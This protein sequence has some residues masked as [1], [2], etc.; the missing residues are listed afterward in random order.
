MNNSPRSVRGMHDWLAEK[1]AD[2]ERLE[3]CARA[4]FSCFGYG[5][6]RTPIVEELGLFAR[7]LGETTD[8]VEKEMFLLSARDSSQA[9]EWVLR[10]EG[11]AGVVRACL[12]H[13]LLQPGTIQKLFYMGPMFRAERPQAGRYRQ[14]VQLGAESFGNAAPSADAESV[15]LL[16][17]L[18]RA[19]GVTGAIV[20]LNSLGC[21]N[22][23]PRF[24]AELK[25]FLES[26]AQTLCRDCQRRMA[27]NPLRALDCKKDAEFLSAAPR[28]AD[29]LCAECGTHHQQFLQF[30]T[31]ALIP[32]EES[33][34]LVRGLDYYT[35]SVFEVYASGRDGAQ[36]ALAAGGR[37]DKLV[38]E[39]GGYPTPAVGFALGLERVMNFLASQE[40]KKP[41]QRQ[42]VFVITL[43][44]AARNE[45]F[46]I[47][48]E[49]RRA[50]I[51][52]DG[53]INAQSLKSQMRLANAKLFR[54]AVLIGENELN[55][56]SLMLKDL[57]KSEQ[58]KI[59][60]TALLEKIS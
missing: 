59:T 58:E 4:I 56:G 33:A 9:P 55:E 51:V 57:E 34:R 20:R 7:A 47:L 36:D 6:I 38:E 21:A 41:P 32:F 1:C 23:R 11:T 22:C 2:A 27:K 10:P 30:L 35:R 14:F 40:E 49:L 48:Q 28:A 18:L 43:G 31:A 5:E 45:G 53:V 26:K 25:Q 60:R 16:Y 13:K 46:A 44:D 52:A 15:V 37:Y 8:I 39:F 17:E 54:W 19:F 50:G 12:E 42:G 29:F 3:R 24:H